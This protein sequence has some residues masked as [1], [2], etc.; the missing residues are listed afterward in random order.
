MCLICKLEKTR[1]I[2]CY[3]VFKNCLI[4]MRNNVQYIYYFVS[5]KQKKIWWCIICKLEQ[6]KN[7]NILGGVLKLFNIYEK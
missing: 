3:E 7:T 6:T 1:I 2:I 4:Y 5:M